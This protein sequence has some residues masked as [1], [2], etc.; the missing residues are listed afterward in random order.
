MTTF[1]WIGVVT[2]V[3]VFFGSI[4]L[5]RY[6]RYRDEKLDRESSQKINEWK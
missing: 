5:G 1:Q 6:L 4:G 3:V 2:L